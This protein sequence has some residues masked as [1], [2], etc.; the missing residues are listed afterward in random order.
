MR[1]IIAMLFFAFSFSCYSQSSDAETIKK[2]NRDWLN[3]TVK[4]DTAILATIFA[5]D[6][7][8]YRLNNMTFSIDPRCL[9]CYNRNIS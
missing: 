7:L 5:S 9:F 6:F 8:L 2:L 4:G 1:T 3:A